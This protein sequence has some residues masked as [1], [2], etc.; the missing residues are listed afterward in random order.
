MQ[1]PQA[2]NKDTK[3]KDYLLL[4]NSFLELETLEYFLPTHPY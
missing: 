2:H 3:A 4:G 1:D